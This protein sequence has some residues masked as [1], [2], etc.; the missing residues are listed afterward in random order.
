MKVVWK[1]APINTNEVTEKL[2][3][4][5]NW[6]PKTI[7]TMVILAFRSGRKLH[8]LEKS[9]LPLQNPKVREIYQ[10]CLSEMGIRPLVHCIGLTSL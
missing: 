2:T 4:T 10:E 8:A 6:S 7:Q 9:A 3:Q 1:Y 5:T